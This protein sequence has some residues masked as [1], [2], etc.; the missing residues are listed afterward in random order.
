MY[1]NTKTQQRPT[2]VRHFNTHEP[3]W[4]VKYWWQYE[5]YGYQRMS[6]Y[7][8]V[9]IVLWLSWHMI[10]HDPQLGKNLDNN[11]LIMAT[12]DWEPMSEEEVAEYKATHPYEVD[13]I[14]VQ[15][16]YQDWVSRQPA[17]QYLKPKSKK[18]HKHKPKQ[19]KR[20]SRV[21]DRNK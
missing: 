4:E 16:R 13:T 10:T 19:G 12:S 8:I 7:L 17:T 15:A 3:L 20:S 21:L 14:P 1:V 2:T 18:T 9:V 5:S 11:P 6:I